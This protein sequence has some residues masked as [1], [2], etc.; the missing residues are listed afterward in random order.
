MQNRKPLEVACARR[1][2]C[3]Q[4]S[5]KAVGVPKLQPA[6]RGKNQSK[7]TVVEAAAHTNRAYAAGEEKGGEAGAAGDEMRKNYRCM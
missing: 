6:R 1:T 3:M 7:R 5:P 4:G 2:A